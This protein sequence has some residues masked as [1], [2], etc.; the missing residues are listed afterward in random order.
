MAQN[1]GDSGHCHILDLPAE[2]RLIISETVFPPREVQVE[3]VDAAP[4]HVSPSIATATEPHIAIPDMGLLSACKTT[5]AETT[6][7]FYGSLTFKLVINAWECESTQGSLLGAH[8]YL[9]RA[10]EVGRLSFR[11]LWP[12]RS[13]GRFNHIRRAKISMALC[14]AYGGQNHEQVSVPTKVQEVVGCLNAAPKLKAVGL[15]GFHEA[16]MCLAVHTAA[17]AAVSRLRHQY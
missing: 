10:H 11:R 2:L 15:H 9:A 7:L 16:E 6:P 1:I 8:H 5:H 13:F 14:D 4:K 12:I 3:V 17:M